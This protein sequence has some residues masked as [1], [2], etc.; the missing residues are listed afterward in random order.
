MFTLLVV[1]HVFVSILLIGAVLIQSGRGA[2]TANIFGGARA[3]ENVFGASTPSILNRITAVLA[4]MFIITSISLTIFSGKNQ[5]SVIKR[6]LKSLPAPTQEFPG[7]VNQEIPV[8]SQ[9]PVNPAP[10][11]VK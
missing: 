4:A 7:P 11:P 8:P 6:S 10:T 1:L 2:A 3:A 9:A 5:R